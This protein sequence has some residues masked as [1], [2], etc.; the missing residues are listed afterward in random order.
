MPFWIVAEKKFVCMYRLYRSDVGALESRKGDS[1]G[2][3]VENQGQRKI[4]LY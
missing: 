1:N 4:Y 2:K 3:E